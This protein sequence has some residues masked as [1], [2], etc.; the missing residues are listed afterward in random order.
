MIAAFAH[1]S[2]LKFKEFFTRPDSSLIKPFI[3]DQSIQRIMED[4]I[5]HE[6]LHE[7][8]IIHVPFS[9]EEDKIVTDILREAGTGPLEEAL[10][11]IHKRL[12]SRAITD[13]RRYVNGHIF[14]IIPG[15]T[16][17]ETQVKVYKKKPIL[18]SMKLQKQI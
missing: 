17:T 2:S 3:S 13:I 14:R 10:L 11:S 18:A 7:G 8:D 9:K 1:N 5:V 12:P 16:F 6:A 15:H 4:D